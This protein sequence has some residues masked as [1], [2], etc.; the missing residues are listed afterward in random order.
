MQTSPK[1]TWMPLAVR[2]SSPAFSAS[3][4]L[5]T[6][7]VPFSPFRT[8]SR[9]PL[10]P[11]SAVSGVK[12]TPASHGMTPASSRQLWKHPGKAFTDSAVERFAPYVNQRFGRRWTI[13]IGSWIMVVGAI[14]QAFSQHVGMVRLPRFLT[15]PLEKVT[16]LPCRSTLLLASFSAWAFCSASLPELH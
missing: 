7:W 16:N 9:S 1:A 15:Q 11:S 3:S 2:G 10:F 13:M 6:C 4:T 8:L 12:F 14:I 5:P